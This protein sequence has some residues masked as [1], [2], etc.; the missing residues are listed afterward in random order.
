MRENQACLRQYLG[1]DEADGFG[2]QGPLEDP[3][4]EDGGYV[5]PVATGQ[6][7]VAESEQ[8]DQEFAREWEEKTRAAHEAEVTHELE[9]NDQERK[10][11]LREFKKRMHAG[12]SQ[13]DSQ[14]LLGE[15]QGKLGSIDALLEGEG[16]Q[17]SRLLSDAME[18][19]KRRRAGMQE[20]VE[21][22]AEKQKSHSEKFSRKLKVIKAQEQQE[23][24][25]AELDVQ[26]EHE[27]AKAAIDAKIA[28]DRERR[29]EKLQKELQEF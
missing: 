7:L 17:Q 5:D 21:T 24:K 6:A 12:A 14:A 16:A 11:A 25:Q 28:S 22:L 26:Q 9:E 3:A 15:I 27:D 8:H 19:R 20:T 2:G 29:V 10:K 23:L 1:L 18:R 13:E 4:A